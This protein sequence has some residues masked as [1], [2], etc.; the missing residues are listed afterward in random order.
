MF[1]QIFKERE[2][3][4]EELIQNSAEA[5]HPQLYTVVENLAIRNLLRDAAVHWIW[6]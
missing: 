1:T 3:K 4:V 5:I 6:K 2:N